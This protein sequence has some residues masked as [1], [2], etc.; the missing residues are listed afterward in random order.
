M[1][2]TGKST[3][4]VALAAALP[5]AVHIDS[6]KERK[7]MFG[8]PE[9]ERLPAEAYTS[10]TS[11][12]L[13]DVLDAAIS[14]SL[15]AGKSV[16][17][18]STFYTAG[19]IPRA[20]NTAAEAGAAFTG[21]LLQADVQTLFDRVSKRT[22]DASDAG[23]DIVALQDKRRVEFPAHWHRVNAGRAREDVLAEALDILNARTATAKP[24]PKGPSA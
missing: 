9:T 3:L 6:D 21:I 16:V 14:A 13:L 22:N 1:S 20:E 12:R 11:Q 24:A 15:A 7:K 19:S 2:G 5:D 10:E 4:A 17:L 8:V 23:V 18:S